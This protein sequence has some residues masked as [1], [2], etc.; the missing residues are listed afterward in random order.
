MSTPP[1]RILAP[2]GDA[3]PIIVH[4]P[5][6]AVYLPRDVR[7]GILLSDEELR[8]ELLAMTDHRTDVLAEDTGTIG[9]TRFVNR[10]SRLAVDPERFEDPRLEEM[11]AV[12]MGAVYTATSQRY[13]LREAVP[14]SRADLLERH[15]HPYHTAFTSLVDRFL[16][17]HGTCVIIDLHS[18]PTL[19]LPYELHRDRPH[20][21]ADLSGPCRTRPWSQIRRG[22]PRPGR[23]SDP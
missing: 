17:A 3:V 22:R 11:E 7:A 20:P 9:A 12:G 16:T 1:Y 21:P 10:W 23:R 19:A 8:D 2:S 14:A 4:V 5:H 18:H 6:S 13:P 15:F